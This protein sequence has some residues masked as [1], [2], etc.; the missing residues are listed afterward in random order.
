MKYCIN[1][2]LGQNLIELLKTL[3]NN[4][5][6]CSYICFEKL[7][8]IILEEKIC[9][10]N[11]SQNNIYKFEYKRR[12]YKSCQEGTHNS[13]YNNYICVK[14]IKNE[15]NLGDIYSQN[16]DYSTNIIN[17]SSYSQNL[18]YLTNIINDSSYSQNL[19][20]L[21]NIINDSLNH[22]IIDST[23][24]N[25]D[26]ININDFS[27][28]YTSQIFQDLTTNITIGST[29]YLINKEKTNYS[30]YESTI[31][32]LILDYKKIEYESIII[33]FEKRLLNGSLDSFLTKS[34]IEEKENIII[35]KEDITYQI[36]TTYIQNRATY[37][38]YSSIILG[39]C[40]K[41]LKKYYNY[42]DNETI[43]ILKKENFI[44]DSLIPIIDYQFFSLDTKKKLNISICNNNSINLKIP[45]T[46]D[47]EEIFKYNPT[48]DYYTD[49]CYPY[50]T[51]NGTDILLID[52]QYEYNYYNM[53][54]CEN[55]CSFINYDENNKKVECECKV[56]LKSTDI[57]QENLLH[58]NFNS[59]NSS[60]NM[61]SMKCAYTLFTKDGI[62]Y[63]IANYILIL[64]V[65]LFLISSI[66]F[67]KCGYPLLEDD[68][69]E[70]IELKKED[71]KN[72]NIIET[73][74]INTKIH[75]IKKHKNK[76]KNKI[77]RKYLKNSNEISLNKSN[78]KSSF[79]VL[80][81]NNNGNAKIN[82]KKKNEI[83]KI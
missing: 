54:V 57:D 81:I 51:K 45:V 24:V 70:I 63:N 43:L 78:N 82:K 21:T 18:E 11:C 27:K 49:V 25:K 76:K 32:D 55:N 7:S 26:S 39:Q 56:K 65:L 8:K 6:E 30:I 50:T 77:N 48:S 29:D 10:Y 79:H 58:Y 35:K 13:T 83:H 23:I 60:S 19:E 31:S 71:K 17:V 33:D 41:K 67:Y 22:L 80:N 15:E 12:C 66:V 9:V 61:I 36:T 4:N 40:E 46:I 42:S 72:K 34:L 74:C 53:A 69:K 73:N 5:N 64:F 28:D 37:D 2:T 38:N 20:Y 75:K 3:G 47:E 44:K 16:M 1:E 52:R 62:L 14:D 68:I 59:K